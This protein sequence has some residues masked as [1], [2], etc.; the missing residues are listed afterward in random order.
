[1]PPAIGAIYSAA[2]ERKR[3]RVQR[4]R[5]EAAVL[6]E[7]TFGFRCVRRLTPPT[8]EMLEPVM[9]GAVF[10]ERTPVDDQT[11]RRFLICMRMKNRRISKPE[12]S[13]S[14]N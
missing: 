5:P 6:R 14:T 2:R 8:E 7:A 4:L 10:R 3:L 13:A 1:M 9:L 12:S 11:F